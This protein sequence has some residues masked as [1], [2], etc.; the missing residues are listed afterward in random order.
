MSTKLKDQSDKSA[1]IKPSKTTITKE[2]W[3]GAI[4]YPKGLHPKLFQFEAIRFALE[5]NRSYLALDPGLGKT[6]IAALIARNLAHLDVWYVCPPFLVENTYS[7]MLKWNEEYFHRLTVI[8]DNRL[9]KFKPKSKDPVLLIVDEAHRFKN[10]TA[11]RTKSLF[12]ILFPCASRCVFM[13]GTPMPNRPIELFPVLSVAAPETIDFKNRFQYGLR[14]CAGFQNQWGWDFTGASNVS[15]LSLKVKSNFM[16]RMRK[17]DVLEELPDKMEEMIIL[18]DEM[19]K[20]VGALDKSILKEYSPEDLMKHT[21]DSPHT[22][23][24]R[25]ELGKAKCKFAIEFLKDILENSN[26]ALLVF[27]IHRDVIAKLSWALSEYNPVVITGETPTHKR[28]DLVKGF[29]MEGGSKLFIGNIQ[30]AGVGFTLTRSARVVFV[31]FDWVPGNNEQASDRAHR[32]GQ[33]RDVLVSYLVFKNSID[34]T[35]L[36]TILRKRKSINLV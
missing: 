17:R 23:T 33:N 20:A 9:D 19:P 26:E 22:A 18:S 10:E 4:R 24:Y 5:R 14:Y 8:P 36:E 32:I 1:R 12:N 31:E 15:E 34:R 21:L 3:L 11:K 25:K 2:P 29:Q 7:E 30:A 27:A 35:V 28:N 16:L 6:I 13:S